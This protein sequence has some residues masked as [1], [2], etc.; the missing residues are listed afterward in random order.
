MPPREEAALDVDATEVDDPVELRNEDIFRFLRGRS[1]QKKRMTDLPLIPHT[2]IESRPHTLALVSDTRSSDIVIALEAALGVEGTV[3][4]FKTPLKASDYGEIA[5]TCS[6]VLCYDCVHQVNPIFL[7]S[8]GSRACIL[9]LFYAPFNMG[10]HSVLWG[11]REGTPMGVSLCSPGFRKGVLKVYAQQQVSPQ[12]E[13]TLLHLMGRLHNVAVS[14]AARYAER[15]CE[16][17]LLATIMTTAHVRSFHKKDDA[18]ALRP[19]LHRDGLDTKLK[20]IKNYAISVDAETAVGGGSDSGSSTERKG[21][22]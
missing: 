19:C 10:W 6:G 5:R 4:V 15:L 16:G 17:T 20:D 3:R 12:D 1:Q 7:D 11:V 18:D 14:L 9:R 22:D 21:V 13:E 8:F 2:W